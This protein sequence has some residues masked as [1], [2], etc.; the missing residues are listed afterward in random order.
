MYRL[1]TVSNIKLLRGFNRFYG[2]PTAPN[3]TQGVC[4]FFANSTYIIITEK[5]QTHIAEWLN[6]TLM[7]TPSPPP[8]PGIGNSGKTDAAENN[9]CV[10]LT[11]LKE[12]M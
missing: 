6:V 10:C 9:N 8:S 3:L 11:C 7:D 5:L 4:H 2:I 1:G 12:Q